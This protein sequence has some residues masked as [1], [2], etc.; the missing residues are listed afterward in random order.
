MYV[1]VPTRTGEDGARDKAA[2][3][4]ALASWTARTNRDFLNKVREVVKD[5]KTAE[6]QALKWF[7][8]VNSKTYSREFGDVFAHPN[9]TISHG[10]DC[11]DSAIAL[12]AGILALG[13]PAAPDVV[14]R[15][16]DGEYNGCHVR[17]RVGLPP[18]DPPK[19]MDKWKIL[20]SS[21]LGEKNWVGGGEIY[22]PKTKSYG[23]DTLTGE[24]QPRLS[25][26]GFIFLGIIAAVGFS[27]RIMEARR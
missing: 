17:V 12:L 10:G 14:L 25:A 15:K 7:E 22:P 27:V 21:K 13:I 18:H 8:F 4:S 1:Q 26:Q 23:E 3:I 6:G 24:R 20:D 19:N 5:E 9:S 16:V 2:L 11:D